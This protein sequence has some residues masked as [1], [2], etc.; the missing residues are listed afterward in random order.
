MAHS[1]AN[2]NSQTEGNSYQCAVR[3]ANKYTG[4]SL[5]LSPIT[6][7]A[8]ERAVFSF[9]CAPV[10]PSSAQNRRFSALLHNCLYCTIEG[11]RDWWHGDF[12]AVETDTDSTCYFC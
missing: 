1:Q 3:E 8:G 4:L 12:P 5:F 10:Y 11:R 9:V 6:L 2:T 7:A